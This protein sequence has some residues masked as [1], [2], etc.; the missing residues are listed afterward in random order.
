MNESFAMKLKKKYTG[1][2]DWYLYNLSARQ[3]AQGTSIASKLMYPMIHFCDNEKMIVYLETNKEGNV[4][5]YHH[6]G[7]ELQETKMIPGS[8]VAHYSMICNPD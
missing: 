6:Y 3:S 2:V 4:S 5:M 7:F 8:S 1:H